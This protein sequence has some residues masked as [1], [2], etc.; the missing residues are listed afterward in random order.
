MGRRP[1]IETNNIEKASKL[2]EFL[3]PEEREFLGK[4]FSVKH[5]KKNE[6]IYT[7]GETPHDLLCLVSGKVKIF[8]KGVGGRTQ[9]VRII[10]AVEH[11][12]Y[13]ALL[14]EE[15]Y[16][17]NATAMENSTVYVIP[18]EVFISLLKQNHELSFFFIKSL[19][20]DLGI[21]DSRS[22][23]LT[24]QHIRG[25][26]AESLLFLKDSYGY[27]SDDT[28]IAIYLSRED[29]AGISNMTASNVIRT[30]AVFANEKIIAVDGRKIKI[31]DE[32]RLRQIGKFE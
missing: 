26:L 30:L 22:V 29:L 8:R 27:E 19:A 32:D 13:R 25:R 20:T 28:T 17:T 11:F 24:Q 7:E 18:G 6:M 9:I 4:N 23:N 12:A 2:W 31:I 16:V 1:T 21:S 3:T 5:Y 15:P 10:K 14:A